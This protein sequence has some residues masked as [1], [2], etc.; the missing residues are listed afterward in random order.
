MPDGSIVRDV[1]PTH[2]DDMD[3]ARPVYE[4]L[5][6]WPEFHAH[7][8]ERL[9][10]EGASALP[11]PLRR[12]LDHIA[13][14]TGVPVEYVGYGP[15]RDETL[16]LPPVVARP[17]HAASRPGRASLVSFDLYLYVAFGIGILAGRMVHPPG[18]WVEAATLASVVMLIG[19]LGASL[20]SVALITLA[21]TIPL[22]V[23]FAALLL[24]LT[25]GVYLVLAKLAP[26]IPAPTVPEEG[27][28]RFPVSLGLVGALLAGFALGHFIALPTALAIPWAL[29]ALLALVG[30][31]LKLA[32]QSL[33]R[34][35][36]PVSASVVAAGASAVIFALT[37][38]RGLDVSFATAFAF[39]WYTLAGPLVAARL[40]AALGLLAFLTNFLR[41]DL[42]MLLSPVLGRRLRGEGLA[43][44][45]GATSMDTTLY[46]VTRYGD[47]EAG[48]LALA[49]GLILT[50]TASLLLPAI[51]AL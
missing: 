31:G 8:R 12:F 38:G 30:F 24:G 15:G 18:R 16:R 32:W 19:L 33:G 42:T 23:G 41:E 17:A 3:R 27:D 36:V 26:P 34:A 1:L 28:R 21:S 11:T 2:A 45:G 5:P 39:G 44:L 50:V 10:R 4:R 43:A 46:F 35:W 47:A 9:R 6:G 25:A 14:E 22:A 37:S 40:G 29:Y 48:S 49:S 20:D 7:L 51:L 13:D